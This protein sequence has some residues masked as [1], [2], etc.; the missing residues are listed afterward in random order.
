MHQII[1]KIQCNDVLSPIKMVMNGRRRLRTRRKRF[2][3][4]YRDI[5]YLALEACGRDNIDIGMDTARWLCG[6]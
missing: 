4:M 2:R 3:S 5:M 6:L 1:S